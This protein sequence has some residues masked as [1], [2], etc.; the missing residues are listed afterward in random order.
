[1]CRIA[2]QKELKKKHS[3]IAD[4]NNGLGSHFVDIALAQQ[5]RSRRRGPEL[6]RRITLHPQL[7]SLIFF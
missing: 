3:R 7:I 4:G 2:M 5:H 6:H 1:M